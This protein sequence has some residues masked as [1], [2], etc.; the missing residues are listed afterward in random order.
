MLD[1]LKDKPDQLER[2]KKFLA[3]LDRGDP[4]AQARWQQMQQ[5]GASAQGGASQ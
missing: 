1:A 2:R 4:Q 5:R 3:D